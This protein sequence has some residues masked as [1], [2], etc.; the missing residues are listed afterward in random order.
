MLVERR[1]VEARETV[2]VLREMSR[3]PVEDDADAGLVA[4][5]DEELEILRRAVAA[6]RRKEADHL[7]AP[8]ASERMLHHRQQ[9]DVRKA[10]LHHVGH[11]TRRKLAVGQ[12]AVAV[13]RHS[14]PRSEVHLIGGHR[15]LHP[16]AVFLARRHPV[17]VLPRVTGDIANDRG[18]LRRQL[19]GEAVGVALLQQVAGR[20]PNLEFVLLAVL[21]IRNEQFPHARE[22][23]VPHRVQAA[24]P[25]VEV[26]DHAHPLGAW[27]PDG[28]VHAGGRADLPPV[29]TQDLEGA[30][31]RALAEQV[32]V[33][34][35]EHAA[36]AVGIVHLGR[37]PAPRCRPQSIVGHRPRRQ[38]QL[39][40]AVGGE[41][42]HRRQLA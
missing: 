13:F 33:E 3:H 38:R 6:G 14:R 27:R 7:V 31:M 30:M 26:A 9:L 28:E 34:L 37:Q 40:Q 42:R 1:P 10:H 32:Q 17:A 2:R 11:E 35:G 22:R 20:G 25:R 19:E 4:R 5:V 36:V 15:P 16:A 24:V 8:R 29:R 12:H 39:E 23:E 41:P 21:Q 18:G